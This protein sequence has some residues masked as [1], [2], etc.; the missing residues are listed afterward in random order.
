MIFRVVFRCARDMDSGVFVSGRLRTQDHRHSVGTEEE[1]PG[2]RPQEPYEPLPA[3]LR[4]LE[5]DTVEDK[6]ARNVEECQER[7]RTRSV[8]DDSRSPPTT[9]E[10][11]PGHPVDVLVG[12]KVC[13]RTSA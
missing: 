7:S 2:K 9:P 12:R 3:R 11:A 6:F 8:R 10:V 5:P 1:D 13:T 4:N